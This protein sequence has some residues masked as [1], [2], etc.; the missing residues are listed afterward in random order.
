M[1]HGVDDRIPHVA[2]TISQAARSLTV[3]PRTIRR[4]IGRGELRALHIGRAVRIPVA[5]LEAY[6][7]L[8]AREAS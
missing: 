3:S 8:G 7:R 2:Y 6:T 4:M 1:L 5:E